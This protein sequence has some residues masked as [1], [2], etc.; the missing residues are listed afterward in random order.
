MSRRSVKLIG[1]NSRTKLDQ[2][3]RKRDLCFLPGLVALLK[4]ENKPDRI[5]DRDELSDDQGMLGKDAIGAATFPDLD[6]NSDAVHHLHQL[7]AL[8]MK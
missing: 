4:L 7:R 1:P 2:A 8:P 6:R 5:A 3:M